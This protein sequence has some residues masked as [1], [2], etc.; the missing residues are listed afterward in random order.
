M[1]DERVGDF[2]QDEKGLIAP[3]QLGGM[4]ILAVELVGKKTSLEPRF[5]THYLVYFENALGC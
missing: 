3:S 4:I 1:I 5:P 2:P